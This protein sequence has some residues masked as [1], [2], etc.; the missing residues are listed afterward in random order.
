MTK[1]LSKDGDTMRDTFGWIASVGFSYAMAQD[2]LSRAMEAAAR[3]DCAMEPDD[4]ARFLHRLNLATRC[5]FQAEKAT[6]EVAR[7]AVN[8]SASVTTASETKKLQDAAGLAVGAYAAAVAHAREAEA[9]AEHYG[10]D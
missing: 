10:H 6:A 8:Y 9:I 3:E 2:A 7:E 4:V 5:L 1:R